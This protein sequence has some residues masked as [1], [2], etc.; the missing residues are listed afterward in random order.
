MEKREGNPHP[1]PFRIPPVNPGVV[2]III[3]IG[4]VLMGV[5]AF[6]L[7]KWFFLSALALGL[8]VALLLRYVR[9]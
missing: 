4:F 6:P 3:A 5:I 2:G 7:G 1:G 8:A 9:R